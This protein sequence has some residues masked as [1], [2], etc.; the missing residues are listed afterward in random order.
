MGNEWFEVDKEG[1]SKLL[2][3]QD[4]HIKLV[5]ELI[6]NALDTNA[7][8]VDV[9]MRPVPNSPLVNLT[10]VDDDPDGFTDLS[11]AYT[12]FAESE[13]KGD[14]SKRGRFNLGEKMVLSLC[15]TATITSTKGCVYFDANGKRNRSKF[16]F[17]KVGSE[18][19]GLIRMTRK[20]MRAVEEEL[21]HIISDIPVTVNG[22]L[23]ETR[24]PICTFSA[25]LPTLIS[26]GEGVL[27]RTT[28]K[29]LVNVYEAPSD[30]GARIYELGIPV[31]ETGDKFDIDIR[32]KVPLNLDRDNVP[33]AYLRK[34][35]VLI[36]N[37][38]HDRI[39]EEDANSTWVQDASASSDV[40]EVAFTTVMNSRFGKDRVVY[41]LS[42]P[43]ANAQAINAGASVIHGRSLSKEQWEN[44]RRFSTISPA[45]QSRFASAKPYSDDPN[46]TPVRVLAWDEW[47]TEMHRVESMAKNLCRIAHGFECDVRITYGKRNHSACYGGRCLDFNLNVLGR[48]WFER[49]DSVIMDLVIHELAHEK[50]DNHLEDSF[51]GECTRIAGLAFER[52]EDVC[53]A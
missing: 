53:P 22:Q 39:D 20:Q 43:E 29:S 41:D 14:P 13:K 5:L 45:G 18:F 50:A 15:R 27:T 52:K 12:L 34:L 33:P 16:R 10:V 48:A 31:V 8:F 11:H 42:D 35:R 24:K 36:L 23:M 49:P 3:G 4:I 47:T 38:L 46:A 40:S 7:T 9:T 25:S 28:R 37:N 44:S 17:R 1:L 51:H 2:E 32:Q 21:R 6:Q 19:T 30:V 26:N